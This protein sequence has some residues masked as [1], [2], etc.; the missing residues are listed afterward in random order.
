MSITIVKVFIGSID[1]HFSSVFQNK[2]FYLQWK[3]STNL[4][5]WK[6][7]FI[8]MP[9][10]HT[11]NIGWFST[12]RKAI[13]AKHQHQLNVFW[14]EVMPPFSRY[15]CAKEKGKERNENIYIKKI[16]QQLVEHACS[17]EHSVV[18][19]HL[20]CLLRSEMSLCELPKTLFQDR[21]S[22]FVSHWSFRDG[23][24][25][26]LDLR[27]DLNLSS[28]SGTQVCSCWMLSAKNVK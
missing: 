25:P 3:Q 12:E 22:G 11:G 24:R 20:E 15:L 26:V 9:D 21:F 5:L 14:L 6:S 17:W 16:T 28:Q 13:N 7:N 4:V 2:F 23:G 19:F 18:C 8:Y 1:T 27:T 10:K